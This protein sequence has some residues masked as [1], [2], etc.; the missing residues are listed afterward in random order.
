MVDG[1]HWSVVLDLVFAIRATV[2]ARR[3]TICFA[4]LLVIAAVAAPRAV[5]GDTVLLAST[6]DSNAAGG[7]RI[8]RIDVDTQAVTLIGNTGLDRMGGLR[9]SRD[10]VLYGVSGGSASANDLVRIDPSTAAVTP[11]GTIPGSGS[12]NSVDGL[13]F[14]AANTL[15]GVA[16][17]NS[18]GA[19]RLVTLDPATAAVLTSIV[20]FGASGNNFVAGCDFDAGGQLFGS[21]GNSSGH[22]EDLDRVE[23]ATGELTPIGAATDIISDIAFAADGRLFGASPTGDLFTIDPIDGSK[24]LLFN[25][26]VRMAGLTA[27]PGIPIGTQPAPTMSANGLFVM[28]IALALIGFGCATRNQQKPVQPSRAAEPIGQREP[29]FGPRG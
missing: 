16:F 15:F 14:N 23:A 5:L 1:Q 25:T 2:R 29:N 17:D 24:T 21:R 9:F 22:T 11:I 19:G 3:A 7:G 13:C 8:Y 4:W 27:E 20:L 28:I 6:G 12:M 26:G 18:G 10:G